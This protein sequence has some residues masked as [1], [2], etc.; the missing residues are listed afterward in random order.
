MSTGEP[1]TVPPATRE[2]GSADQQDRHR[3]RWVLAT[4]SVVAVAALAA[5][6][7]AA[8]PG[9]SAAPP[10]R[11][12]VTGALA[13][14]AAQTFTFSLDT[15]VRIPTEVVNSSVV[16]GAYNL[17]GHLGTE[18]L[19]AREMGHAKR[20]QI[21]YVG[22]N[23]YTAVSPVS[24][25]GKPRDKSALSA[26]AAAGMLP[27]DLYGFVS[28]EPV[29]PTELDVVLRSAG[30]VVRRSGP[31]S[32]PGWTG[33]RYTFTAS[34]SGGRQS[35]TGT[36]DVDRQGQVR[37]MTTTTE[38]RHKAGGKPFDTITR[39]FTFGS[40]GA[41]VRVTAPPASQVKYTSGRPYWGFYF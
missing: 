31:V 24:G 34:L 20:A 28:D 9:A 5:G 21:R 4:G 10:P 16:S 39:T 40:F 37:R 3:R 17:G 25:F 41:V 32:G 23:E 12:A 22:A 35:V 26:A 30:T 13:R 36:T 6:I 7:I 33:T 8:R 19:A 18:R 29:S 27:G 14:T 11:S 15:T 2:Q 38:K 1:A